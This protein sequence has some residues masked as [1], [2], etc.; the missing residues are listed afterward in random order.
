MGLSH[1]QDPCGANLFP[2]EIT[3]SDMHS[4][5]YVEC[6]VCNVEIFSFLFIFYCVLFL[7]QPVFIGF[8]IFFVVFCSTPFLHYSGRHNG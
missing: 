3:I 6:T 2:A 8:C 4:V 5:E 1:G 7:F